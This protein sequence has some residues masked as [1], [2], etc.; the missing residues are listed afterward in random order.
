MSGAVFPH[1]GRCD[2][3]AS[4]LRMPHSSAPSSQCLRRS[5]SSRSEALIRRPGCRG[6]AA[7]RPY[8]GSTRPRSRLSRGSKSERLARG[9]RRPLPRSRECESGRPVGADFSSS[10]NAGVCLG[11]EE[12]ARFS[13]FADATEGSPEKA[14][15]CRAACR[16]KPWAGRWAGGWGSGGLGSGLDSYQHRE[17]IR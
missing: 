17:G 15:P 13:E 11:V 9:T 14:A 3:Q 2:S 6:S 5:P 1:T 12:N 4:L 7:E 8:C 16:P 10:S